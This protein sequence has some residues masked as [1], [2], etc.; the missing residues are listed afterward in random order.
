MESYRVLTTSFWKIVRDESKTISALDSIVDERRKARDAE[1]Y[2]AYIKN[3]N[4]LNTLKDITVFEDRYKN[5]DPDRLIEKIAPRKRE[6]LLAIY[7]E[8]FTVARSSDDLKR[9]IEEYQSDDPD[10]LT[11][12]AKER[13]ESV[14]RAEAVEQD[15]RNRELLEARKRKEINDIEMR[16]VGCNRQIAS[17][18]ATIDREREIA[19]VSGYENK[20]ILRQAGEFIVECR[21]AI[22]RD[23]DLYKKSGGGKRLDDLK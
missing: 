19:R 13:L 17:A 1:E 2:E 23:Y 15:L 22:K 8:K 9:F 21:A 11:P 3:F 7:R 20:M 4:S 5:K 16:I 18:Y 6:F 12:R 14:L 10:G